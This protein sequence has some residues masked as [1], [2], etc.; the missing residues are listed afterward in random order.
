MRSREIG[1]PSPRVLR[2]DTVVTEEG[3]RDVNAQDLRRR[4]V[5]SLLSKVEDTRFPSTAVLDR[6]EGV[7]STPEDVEEY[8]EI[9]L[10]KIESSRFPS[11]ALLDRLDAIAAQLE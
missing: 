4:Y 2:P 10:K 8:A 9:L 1:G 7:I 5:A 3:V 11:P 6:I